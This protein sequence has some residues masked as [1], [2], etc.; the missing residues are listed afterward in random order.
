MKKAANYI[1]R[2]SWS[3]ISDVPHANSSMYVFLQLNRFFLNSHE[4]LIKLQ[5]ATR[6]THPSAYQCI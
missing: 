1:R 6:K 4:A 2:R 3:Q 5:R